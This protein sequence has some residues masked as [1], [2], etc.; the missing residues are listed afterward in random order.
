MKIF[1]KPKDR[2]F[3]ILNLSDPQMN[4]FEWAEDHPYSPILK[5]TID[6]LIRRNQPDLITVTGDM[7]YPGQFDSYEAF[8]QL[9]NLLSLHFLNIGELFALLHQEDRTAALAGA[10]K[11]LLLR[12]DIFKVC[13]AIGAAHALDDHMSFILCV[14][15][16]LYLS[17][18][19]ARLQ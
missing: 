15:D 19:W 11:N 1:Q 3:I 4:G 10:A 9:L 2:D 8:A 7:A 12:L 16:W 13:A 5:Y 18:S 14:D 6:Q 17:I